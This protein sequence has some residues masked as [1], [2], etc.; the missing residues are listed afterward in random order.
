[1][2]AAI[3]TNQS[4]HIWQQPAEPAVILYGGD[5]AP[6]K[7]RKRRERDDFFQQIERTIH[8]LLHPVEATPMAGAASPDAAADIG[9]LE[10]EYQALVGL[11][12]ESHESLQA[13]GQ[14]RR[15]IDA[16]I[17]AK[18]AEEEEEEAIMLML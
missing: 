14:I 10:R 16:Y 15:D 12:Q 11:A 13:L 18:R 5:D 17:E 3:Y 6:R 9:N 2:I 7:R 8:A 4:T 1:M